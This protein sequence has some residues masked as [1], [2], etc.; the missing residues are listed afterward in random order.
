MAAEKAASTINFFM[1]RL[2]M[3]EGLCESAIA[4]DQG[5]PQVSS[6]RTDQS[7]MHPPSSMQT[8]FSSDMHKEN[9]VHESPRLIA[10]GGG[11]ATH[12][13]DPALDDFV[14]HHAGIKRPRVGFLGWATD[15]SAARLSRVCQ[16]LQGR[17]LGVHPLRWGATAEQV[18]LWVDQIDVLYSAGG[19]TARLAQALSQSGLGSLLVRA[20]ARGLL[21]VG[22]SAGAAVWFDCALSDAGG[23]GLRRFDGLGLI[24][25]SFCPH[26][27]SEPARRPAFEAAI[28]LGTLPAGLAVDDGVAVLVTSAGPQALCSARA[29][30]SARWVRAQN[31]RVIE[32]RLPA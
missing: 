29:G 3:P 25:G 16:R 6:M 26:Y 7:L 22:V 12:G 27:D 21:I 20:A 19:D 1:R 32:E 9:L 14:L 17:S 18:R 10:L 31:G 5:K 30:A 28:A 8:I 15:D 23:Q 4:I 2:Q 24:P 13:E 11:G